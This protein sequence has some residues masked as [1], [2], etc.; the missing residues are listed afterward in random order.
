MELRVQALEALA[1]ATKLD[2]GPGELLE[3]GQELVL[4][5][6]RV[7]REQVDLANSEEEPLLADAYRWRAER[8]RRLAQ[9]VADDYF[10]LVRAR[11]ATQGAARR[12]SRA[13]ALILEVVNEGFLPGEPA[14]PCRSS[15]ARGSA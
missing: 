11:E 5:L 6:C 3:L 1:S 7:A 4:L 10:F 14:P 15:K 2:A 9:Q 8:L 12:A 13:A